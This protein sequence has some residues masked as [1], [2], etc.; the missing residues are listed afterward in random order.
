MQEMNNKRKKAEG[1]SM[2]QILVGQ[3]LLVM[4]C[5][6]YLI[7]WYRGFRPGV[8][9]NRVGGVNGL[10]LLI[11]AA[12]GLT[13]LWLSLKPGSIE[14]RW[15]VE[16]IW[17]IG[18]GIAEYFVLL[19]IT[20]FVFDRIVTLELFLIVG[21]TMLEIVVINRLNA[22]GVLTDGR[23]LFMCFVI[24]AAFL[25]SMILYVAYY[26]MEEMSAFYA[27]MIPLITE[28]TVMAVLIGAV[29]I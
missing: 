17:I 7:W 21:W 27:A 2:R 6:F 23:F 18:V 12:L 29:I 16:P 8:I 20:R 13:G 5:I 22:A 15:K 4:C 24:A 11:T 28:G 1:I 9:V 19:L 3:A 26:K 25:I 14:G 10:L